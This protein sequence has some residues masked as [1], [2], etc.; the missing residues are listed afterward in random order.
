MDILPVDLL[1]WLARAVGVEHLK[2]VPSTDLNVTFALSLTVFV[3]IIFYSIRMMGDDCEKNA[4]RT[5]RL[6]SAL[7]PVSYR[8]GAGL[9]RKSDRS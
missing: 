6:C 4:R 3:L 9:R 1:P 2:V 7:L 8:C 5:I